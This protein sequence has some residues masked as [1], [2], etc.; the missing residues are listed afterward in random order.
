MLASL[1][2]VSSPHLV[3]QMT[4]RRV[5]AACRLLEER[6][7]NISAD[8]EATRV[9]KI[10]TEACELVRGVDA[11]DPEFSAVVERVI[12][13]VNKGIDHAYRSLEIEYLP[14]FAHSSECPL[15]E[16]PKRLFSFL[17]PQAYDLVFRCMKF[18]FEQWRTH[19][20]Y[21]FWI[22]IITYIFASGVPK[23]WSK[24]PRPHPS[25]SLLARFNRRVT[26][27]PPGM[28]KNI[29]EA[30]CEI[31][32]E[33]VYGDP[34]A[35]V[36]D[37]RGKCLLLPYM[38]GYKQ[39]EPFLTYYLL[40]EPPVPGDFPLTA[41][42]LSLETEMSELWTCATDETRKLIFVA[43][44]EHVK[45][46]AWGD[47]NSTK[48]Y[49]KARRKHTFTSSKHSGPLAVLPSG[50]LI[51]AG[52]GSAAAW[53]LDDNTS[54]GATP[55]NTIT[56]A[57]AALAPAMWYPHPG[58]PA[59]MLCTSDPHDI[60]DRDYSFVSLDLEHGGRTVA[61]Y[62]GNGGGIGDISTSPGDANAFLTGASDGHAR[63][64]DARIPL[65][66]MT[67]CA[68]TGDEDCGG[69]LLA[70]PDGIPAVFTGSTRDE[71]I[72]LW[73]VR[74]RK[75]VYELSTGNNA[76]RGMA[77]D[78]PRNTLYVATNCS[79]MDRNGYTDD[80]R[81]ARLPPS[82][83]PEPVPARGMPNYADEDEE[84]DGG[85]DKCWPKGAKHS[86]DY[87]GAVFD[88]GNH[89]IFRYEF[90]EDPEEVLP[91]YGTATVRGPPY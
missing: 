61:R 80:Y 60:Y 82:M 24:T 74:A 9:P 64:Y 15:L 11:A 57:D 41:R 88:A 12:S 56:F 8:E 47:R 3:A 71:V 81:R 62:F 19:P 22:W 76:V 34:F 32:S 17:T 78:E 51:R 25:S 20:L 86:E 66:V 33:Q 59:T 37:T 31:T 23:P 38:G 73:D 6:L 84:G 48:N 70:H 5:E 39:R 90:K 69:V 26:S 87:W 10:L 18:I 53:N 83:L 27:P 55:M 7:Y 29:Y 35:L 44:E 13:T 2:F 14:S 50:S 42:Y 49:K 43:D 54:T 45:S 36:L 1:L 30:R 77:W 72:R 28:Y 40:D 79:Y 89:R 63:L 16:G 4:L 46:F 75:L 67:F 58:V 68:G 52:K 65:P 91:V 21:P 85:F